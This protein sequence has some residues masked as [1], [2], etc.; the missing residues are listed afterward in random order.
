MWTYARS[1]VRA[2]NAASQLGGL[3]VVLNPILNAAVYYLI[4]GIILG[5]SRG[6]ENFIAFLVIGVFVMNYTARS[7]T[8]GANA[9][10]GN[11]NLI[12]ALHFPRAILPM[13]V[14]LREL[15]EFFV[16]GAVMVLIVLVT[17][18][19]LSAE[20]LAL[21]AIIAIQTLFNLGLCFTFARLTSQVRDVKN[22]L[23]FVTR[24]WTYLSGVMYSIDKFTDGAPPWAV[25]L[26]QINP[27]HVYIELMRDA[28]MQTYDAD[29][30][31]WFWGIGWA[32]F[33][34]IGGFLYFW[35][36]EETYGRA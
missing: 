20:W 7:M 34:S 27:A 21:P 6:I 8:S 23:P 26:L 4:F 5:T 14:V 30:T 3:W 22:M 32:L 36:G 29:P 15:L 10:M 17:G 24:T 16:A 1:Q 11:L 13:T 35:R 2:S 33:A 31:L 19:P 18:E 28:L 12:R 25:F 9:I